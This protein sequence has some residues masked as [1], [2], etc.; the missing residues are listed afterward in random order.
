[1][2]KIGQKNAKGN[3][4]NT[5]RGIARKGGKTKTNSKIDKRA[6]IKQLKNLLSSSPEKIQIFEKYT[7]QYESE[8][9]IASKICNASLEDLG[10]LLDNA[11]K[12]PKKI[13]AFEAMVAQIIAKAINDRDI[14]AFHVIKEL[15]KE[16]YNSAKSSLFLLELN[17]F[18][19]E[20]EEKVL[21]E[22]F[23][24][25]SILEAYNQIIEKF[26][27]YPDFIEKAQ[28]HF[29]RLFDKAIKVEAIRIDAEKLK[30]V[31]QNTLT[32]EKL[33]RVLGVISA[34]MQNQLG[35]NLDAFY[36]FRKELT[37][38][39]GEELEEFLPAND[40]L[41]EID[42]KETLRQKL[43]KMKKESSLKL[44]QNSSNEGKPK[45]R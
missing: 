20:W 9:A 37:S 2:A 5:T 11:K 41:L 14:S 3:K 18:I 32:Y 25:N 15:K 22:D 36:E 30:Y 35:D 4:G 8:L 39:L 13:S 23:T 24:L 44:L 19:K 26:S 34:T 6:K 28:K 45:I 27:K 29:D 21:K 17:T 38:R 10:L 7:E 43:E 12:N 1:M 31:K 40:P 33:N 16:H 42:I